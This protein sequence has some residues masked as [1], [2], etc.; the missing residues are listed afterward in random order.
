MLGV[1]GLLGVVIAIRRGADDPLEPS[2]LHRQLRAH[3]RAADHDARVRVGG[4]GR[5]HLRRR[6]DGA[7]LDAAG[8]PVEHGSPPATATLTVVLPLDTSSALAV[9]A[10]VGGA[11]GDLVAGTILAAVVG[12][13]TYT[14]LF[15]TLGVRVE[16]S[17]CCGVTL[18]PRL[19]ELHR[20][21]GEFRQPAGDRHFTTVDPV[22]DHRL[23]GCHSPTLLPAVACADRAA[24]RHGGPPRLRLAPADGAGRRLSVAIVRRGSAAR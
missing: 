24:R 18:H 5:L 17:H 3:A 19:G 15:V 14:G 7:C 8:Q 1:L 6:N 10:I 21:L 22:V 23:R 13:L 20:R 9:A 12:V 11:G 4:A 16:A 2:A